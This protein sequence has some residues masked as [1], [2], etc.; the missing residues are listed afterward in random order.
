VVRLDADVGARTGYIKADR[1]VVRGCAFVIRDLEAADRDV[2]R[3]DQRHEAVLAIR[4]IEARAL[5]AR[6]L[7]RHGHQRDRACVRRTGTSDG[8]DL[9]VSA[10]ANACDV[11]GGD[12]VSRM[13]DGSPRRQKAAVVRVVAVGGDIERAAGICIETVRQNRV[14]RVRAIGCSRTD[15]TECEKDREGPQ[16]FRFLLMPDFSLGETR[17]SA[18]TCVERA[19]RG[20]V[21]HPN[22]RLNP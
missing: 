22:G 4:D 3:V 10:A 5:D 7:A 16:H 18:E 8:D 21:A 19:P 1:H 2:A 15:G 6:I 17:R 20:I 12:S 13:L 11:A 9:V 14:G